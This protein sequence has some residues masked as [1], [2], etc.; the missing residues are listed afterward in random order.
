MTIQVDGVSEPVNY[1]VKPADIREPD[2]GAKAVTKEHLAALDAQLDLVAVSLQERNQRSMCVN[3]CGEPV[4]PPS[5][6]ICRKCQDRITNI[7]MALAN[8]PD[9]R[10]D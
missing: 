1:N 2:M 4:C 5:K 6:V 3:G 9:I 7:L 8:D 10:N